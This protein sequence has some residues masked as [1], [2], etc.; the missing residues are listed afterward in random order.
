MSSG[1]LFL[2]VFLACVVEAVE[3]LTIVLAAGTGRD[4]RSAVT[5]VVAGVAVL[6]VVVA[7][8]GPAVTAIPLGGLRLVV[9]GLLLIFGLQWLRKAI[10]RASGLKA[11]HDEDAI[12]ARELAAA[13]AAAP[14]RRGMVADWYSFTLSFKGVVL[15]GL[16]V[17]FIALT[18][19]ANQQNIPLA[20]I[21]ALSAIVVVTVAGIAVR[22]PLARVPENTMKFV[23][24]VMLTSFGIFWGAEGAGA[25]WPGADA[26]LLVVVPVVALFALALVATLRRAVTAPGAVA[27]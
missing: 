17:A 21:A 18:F 9:G 19:G 5:G 10:L 1:A 13:R 8:L 7:A 22:A 26:A 16:E 24:G 14:G 15:E 6:A 25:V 12:Y 2:A 4:W 3:A 11:L 20:A 23:V 27:S